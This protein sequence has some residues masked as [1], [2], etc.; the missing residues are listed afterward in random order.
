MMH[1]NSAFLCYSDHIESL[2]FKQTRPLFKRRTSYSPNLSTKRES[3]TSSSLRSSE[4]V[5]KGLTVEAAA[6]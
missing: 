6:C 1:G 2:A 3:G 4:F 5:V